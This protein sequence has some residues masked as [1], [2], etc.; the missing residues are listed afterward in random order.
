MQL[1]P[2]LLALLGS[3]PEAAVEAA[4]AAGD[5]SALVR[6]SFAG[7][8]ADP[9]ALL[10]LYLQHGRLEDAASLLVDYLEAWATNNPLERC[11]PGAL[12]LPLAPMQQ[13]LSALGAA[14]AA[15]AQAGGKR[16]QAGGKRAADR[17]LV[18]QQR[19]ERALEAHN[20]LMASDLM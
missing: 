10:R 14:A 18:A 8:P 3:P 20:A 12:W 7:G 17:L 1:P 6:G 15:Q 16:A 11:K 9:A 4:A 2:W 19:V 5:G 13:L